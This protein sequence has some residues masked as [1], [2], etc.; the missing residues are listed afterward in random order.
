MDDET[1]RLM[2]AMA[3]HAKAR[4]GTCGHAIARW[5]A[6]NSRRA[7]AAL[8]IDEEAMAAIR[9]TPLPKNGGQLCGLAQQVGCDPKTLEDMTA[10]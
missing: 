5:E 8:G 6:L 1:R 2:L 7:E 9:I 4:S 3:R 10:P